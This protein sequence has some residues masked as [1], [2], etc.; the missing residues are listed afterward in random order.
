[1]NEVTR[2]FHDRLVDETDREW[3]IDLIMDLSSREFR[4]SIER[5]ECFGESKIMVGDLLKLDAPKKLYEVINE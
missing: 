3:F 1:M 5:E 4:S 2:V